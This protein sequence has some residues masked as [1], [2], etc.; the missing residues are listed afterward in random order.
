MKDTGVIS[1]YQ[2]VLNFWKDGNIRVRQ[3]ELLVKTKWLT[4]DQADTIYT[5][6]RLQTP[7]VVTDSYSYEE[8]KAIRMGYGNLL[9]TQPI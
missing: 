5:H 4:V 6:P 9:A 8:V 1:K 3:V 7:L 2:L